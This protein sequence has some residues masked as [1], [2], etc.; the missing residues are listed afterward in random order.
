MHSR[1]TVAESAS[2]MNVSRRLVFLMRE[3]ER[4]GRNDLCLAV[5]RG[6]M[7]IKAALK[8]AKPAKYD[9]A[10]DH[11]AALRH[12]WMRAS[13]DERWQFCLWAFA[14]DDD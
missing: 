4:T 6:E 13:N 14:D 5:Q 11:L 12:H 8:I 2:L 10:I 1:L 9:R 7:T 3:L